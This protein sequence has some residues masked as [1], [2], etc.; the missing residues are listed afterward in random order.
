M[1][2]TYIVTTYSV[3][4]DL[5]KAHGY[6]DDVRA[7][8]GAAEILTVAVV[9]AKYFQNHHER[10]LCILIRLGDIPALSVSRFNRHLHALSAWLFGI[11]T[12]LG[13]LFATGEVFI[14]DRC[15][16]PCVNACVRDGARKCAAKST[17]A[18]VR[19]S[20]RSSSAGVC[21]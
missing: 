19:P 4:D 5:L 12:L 13:E 18:I 6:A 3:I 8:T 16:C 7:T 15:R 21:I 14:I 9:S 2:D 11:V 17:V 10:A 1:N 20:V